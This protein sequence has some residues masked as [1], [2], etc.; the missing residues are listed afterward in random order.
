[1]K[2]IIICI[3]LIFLFV[4][5]NAFTQQL[6]DKVYK[7]VVVDGQKVNKWMVIKYLSDF[8]ERGQIINYKYG[9]SEIKY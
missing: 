3:C 6:G 8:N 4:S 9:R 7:E 1:M 5:S 2:R